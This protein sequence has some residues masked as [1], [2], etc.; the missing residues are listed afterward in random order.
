MFTLI[1]T[2][3]L[4]PGYI[5]SVLNSLMFLFFLLI[6]LGD[7]EDRG[8]VLTAEFNKHQSYRIGFTMTFSCIFVHFGH[9]Q[10]CYLIYPAESPFSSSLVPLCSHRYLFLVVRGYFKAL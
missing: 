6:F 7:F 3:S 4:F 1:S 10:P 5:C 2:P 8:S 9:T